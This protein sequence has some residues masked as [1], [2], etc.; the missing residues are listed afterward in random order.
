MRVCCSKTRKL[1]GWGVSLRSVL[2]AVSR[3][4]EGLE[5]SFPPPPHPLKFEDNTVVGKYTL[6]QIVALA[7]FPQKVSPG[8][9]L[10]L[11]FVNEQEEALC[12]GVKEHAHRTRTLVRMLFDLKVVFR[13][14]RTGKIYIRDNC[15][16]YR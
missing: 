11:T 14:P 7:P 2:W 16:G 13:G 8:L 9:G 15:K 3:P 4:K 10:D 5:L 6:L 12:P 1:P